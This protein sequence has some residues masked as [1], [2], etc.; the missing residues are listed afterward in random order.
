M[1]TLLS[2]SA[3]LNADRQTETCADRKVW[4][5]LWKQDVSLC[6]VLKRQWT[7]W[8]PVKLHLTGFSVTD[9][10]TAPS[11][12]DDINRLRS[13]SN[14]PCY[15]YSEAQS[16]TWTCVFMASI[17]FQSKNELWFLRTLRQLMS[18][19]R[20]PTDSGIPHSQLA[21]SLRLTLGHKLLVFCEGKLTLLSNKKGYSYR[22]E[23][24]N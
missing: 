21:L 6:L 24:R 18:N 1:W 11:Q 8:Q 12:S 13:D 15:T 23:N 7:C 17:K 22:A 20:T 14:N 4:K 2:V 19:A 9:M 3:A 10:K 5:R 16:L